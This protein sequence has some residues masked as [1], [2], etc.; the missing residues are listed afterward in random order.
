MNLFFTCCNNEREKPCE[1]GIF[2][3]KNIE[4]SLGLSTKPTYNTKRFPPSVVGWKHILPDSY[5][6]CHQY[7]QHK[8][9]G[10]GLCYLETQADY[11]LYFQ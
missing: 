9:H 2:T 8:V 6:L 10:Y 3:R 11:T 4:I 7:Y 1:G 5:Q